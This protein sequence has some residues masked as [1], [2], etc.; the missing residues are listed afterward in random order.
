MPTLKSMN[1]AQGRFSK[2]RRGL[3]YLQQVAFKECIGQFRSNIQ[4]SML[5]CDKDLI[6]NVTLPN[7]HL[8]NLVD[9]GLSSAKL[10]YAVR[11]YL[12]D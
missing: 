10:R 3:S 2:N 6:T 11:K 8:R 12:V 9:I 5:T 4:Y 1:A 7:D